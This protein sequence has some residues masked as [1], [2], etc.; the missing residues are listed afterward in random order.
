[1]CWPSHLLVELARNK[2]IAMR[3]EKQQ[4][5]DVRISCIRLSDWL[6]GLERN[7]RWGLV[8]RRGILT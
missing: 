7:Q 3:K 1:M 5:P 8:R 2:E 6:R 4:W